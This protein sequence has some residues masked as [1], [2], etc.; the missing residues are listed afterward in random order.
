VDVET[1]FLHGE[2]EEGE[3]IYMECPQGMKGSRNPILH[4]KK[5]IYRLVQAAKAFYKKLT[6]VLKSIGFESR[7]I[8][9]CLLTRKG[10]KGIVHIAI[11]IDDCFC[12]SDMKEIE[13]VIED[14]KD[15]A[16]K[17]KIEKELN[18]YLSCKLHF[19]NDKKKAWIG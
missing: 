16:F 6:Q 8:D 11:Y 7:I 2:L 18:D 3:E 1:A 10:K 5:T 4:L 9:P 15:S 12:C 19:S 13:Q 14:M 17:L